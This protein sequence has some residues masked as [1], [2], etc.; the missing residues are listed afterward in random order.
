LSPSVN[1]TNGRWI[2][3]II[4]VCVI[5]VFSTDS[6]SSE[7]TAPLVIQVLKAVFPSLSASQLELGNVVFRKAGHILEYF[8]L[9]LLT[10]RAFTA[11]GDPRVL[12]ET[13]EARRRLTEAIPR[14]GPMLRDSRDTRRVWMISAAFVLIVALTDEF[15]QSFVPSRTSSLM[16]VGYDFIGG[17]A[18]VGL[19]SRFRNESR[20]LY[21]HTIL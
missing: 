10:W 3:L 16:D 18:A 8:V 21:S 5:F 6:F 7:K 15:H 17:I 14:V 9:G 11:W 20:A 19:L 13:T 4:W 2:P 1:T 12:N